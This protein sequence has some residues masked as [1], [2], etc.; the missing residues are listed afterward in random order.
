M[1]PNDLTTHLETTLQSVSAL[2][3]TLSAD[4]WQR[5]QGEKWSI[6]EEFEH[7]RLST[8]ATAFILSTAGRSRWHSYTGESRSFEAI[9]TQYQVSLAANPGVTNAATRPSAD[10]QTLADQLTNWTRMGQLVS[11]AVAELTEDELDTN[12]VWKHPSL[13]PLT[14]REMIYFT[15]HHT[16]HHQ[17]SMIQ[18]QASAAPTVI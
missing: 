12:T 16:E 13:G 18:K 1:N 2:L 10:A 17:R 6:A 8:Q 15:I 3:T 5:S 7:L 4:D 14:V 11:V 9:Q